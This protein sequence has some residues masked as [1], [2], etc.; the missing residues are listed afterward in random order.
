MDE[1]FEKYA[2]PSYT[3]LSSFCFIKDQQIDEDCFEKVQEDL[4][5]EKA[6]S[7][8]KKEVV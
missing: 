1:L 7:K 5:K 8:K 6:D 3:D 4:I 2:N